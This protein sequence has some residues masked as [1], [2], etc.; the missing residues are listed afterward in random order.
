MGRVR[1][2][3][4][5]LTAVFLVALATYLQVRPQ[6][7]AAVS[8]APRPAASPGPVPST[9]RS[10]ATPGP[11][12]RVTSASPASR[13]STPHPTAV[14]SQS[15]ASAARRPPLSL[16]APVP[17]LVGVRAP[18][19]HGG[20]NAVQAASR[21]V[22]AADRIFAGP[23]SGHDRSVASDRSIGAPAK[24][25]SLIGSPIQNGGLIRVAELHA[26]FA[27]LAA[28]IA[29]HGQEQTCRQI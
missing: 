17:W 5:I 22:P 25:A 2:S 8:P 10:A 13:T 14:P 23:N 19:R 15:P 11:T 1:I 20:V 18:A 27:G 9:A 29:A 6:R 28:L 21:F 7:A 16:R 12:A 4:W 26:L 24:A 3:T